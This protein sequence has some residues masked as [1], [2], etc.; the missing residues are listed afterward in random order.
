MPGEEIKMMPRSAMI[1]FLLG[2]ALLLCGCATT[3]RLSG[4]VTGPTYTSSKGDFSVP[5]PVSSEV[6]GRVLSDGPNSV[7]FHDN[8][9]SRVTFSSA[10]FSSQSSMMSILQSKGRER[11]LTE[12]AKRQY[13]SEI[14]VHYHPDARDGVISFIFLRPVGPK[15]GVAMFVHGER[16]YVVETDMLPGVQLL[17]QNDERSQADREVWLEGRA[18]ELAQSMNVK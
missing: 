14:D 9:G 13:G 7:T 8:W 16:L 18:V 3:Q 15:T 1:G 11:A 10:T 6:G 17:A 2:A 4:T 5:F 12:F